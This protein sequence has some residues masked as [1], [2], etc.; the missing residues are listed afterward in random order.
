MTISAVTSSAFVVN[1]ALAPSIV[2]VSCVIVPL[3]TTLPLIKVSP[4]PVI[5][6]PF[7]PPVNVNLPAFL[8]PSVVSV[9]IKLSA[10]LVT[11]PVFVISIIL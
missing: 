7:V 6:L 8:I 9:A 3:F 5:V 1:F 2:K 11:S 10:L 4:V